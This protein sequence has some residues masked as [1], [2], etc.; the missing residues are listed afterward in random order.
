MLELVLIVIQVILNNSVYSGFYLGNFFAICKLFL[1]LVN[2]IR[3]FNPK[4]LI[5]LNIIKILLK[6]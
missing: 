5:N 2:Q 6:F 3:Y 1:I 4:L